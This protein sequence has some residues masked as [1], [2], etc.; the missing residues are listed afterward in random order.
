M[1][2]LRSPSRAARADQL[3]A[4]V[5]RH[6]DRGAL[7]LDGATLGLLRDLGMSRG[8]VHGAIDVLVDQGRADV[9]IEHEVLVLRLRRRS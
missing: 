8:D 9:A 2:R 1:S 4:A 7:L 3:A 5:R 6:G